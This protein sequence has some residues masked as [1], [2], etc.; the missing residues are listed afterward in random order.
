MILLINGIIIAFG[1]VLILAG[2]YAFFKLPKARSTGLNKIQFD[3]ILTIETGRGSLFLIGFGVVLLIASF[4]FQKSIMVAEKRI[5]SQDSQLEAAVPS[6]ATFAMVPF[7]Q[8]TALETRVDLSLEKAIQQYQEIQTNTLNQ[9]LNFADDKKFAFMV[10]EAFDKNTFGLAN[11]PRDRIPN[12]KE[13]LIKVSS[14]FPN[15]I[16][17]QLEIAKTY[18]SLYESQADDK[19]EKMY[20]LNK[21]G[22]VIEGLQSLHTDDESEKYGINLVSGLYYRRKGELIIALEMMSTAAE[23]AQP[24]EKYK[25]SFNLGNIYLDLALKEESK[26]ESTEY[27]EKSIEQMLKSEQYSQEQNIKFWQ[28][29]FCIGVIHLQTE[30]YEE[31]IN[32]FMKAF[33]IAEDGEETELFMYYLPKTKGIDRLCKFSSFATKFPEI[34]ES[35]ENSDL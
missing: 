24:E 21:L 16:K 32:A 31:S 29:R 1:V 17:L 8:L 5:E 30:K 9:F 22:E 7:D 27:Y 3:K 20:F 26:E 34:C 35:K 11:V 28:P 33:K 18:R 14:S 13:F 12:I 25:T 19:E 15:N 2:L 10:L 4:Y 23:L 6:G